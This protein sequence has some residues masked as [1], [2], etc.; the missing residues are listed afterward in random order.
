MLRFV[1]FDFE[2][3]PSR[4]AVFSVLERLIA[5]SSLTRFQGTDTLLLHDGAKN[6]VIASLRQSDTK[7][8]II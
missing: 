1:G 4:R 5:D 7:M 2:E 8:S 3:L 6:G